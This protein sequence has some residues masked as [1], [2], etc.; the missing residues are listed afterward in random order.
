MEDRRVSG[1]LYIPFTDKPLIRFCHRLDIKY[2]PVAETS[3]V[4]SVIEEW[5]H[6]T[7]NDVDIE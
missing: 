3:E 1:K 5:N 6:C 7:E 4:R 2:V